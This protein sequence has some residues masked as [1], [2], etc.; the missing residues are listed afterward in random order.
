MIHPTAI[1]HPKAEVDPTV[2]VGPFAVIDENVVVGRHC[3]LGPHVYITGLTTIGAN[4]Q[5][6]A[7][8]VIGN[9]PQDLKY[10][11]DPT[12]LRIGDHNSFREHVTVNRSTNPGN[13]TVI[14]SNNLLMA[15]CHVAHDVVVGNQV[16]IAN[17]ALL[18]GHVTVGDRALISGTCL[19][20]QFVRIGTMAIMQ[21]G[22]GISQDLPP[23][24]IGRGTNFLSGLNVVG[25]RRAG[26]TREQ[27][28]ELRK[29]YHIL[30]RGPGR[31]CERIEKARAA[32]PDE[33][34]RQMIEF[35]A[36]TKRGLCSDSGSR[37]SAA[38]PKED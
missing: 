38:N 29:T 36:S 12:S 17:G 4:N 7:G 25:L 23:F 20:H 18:A 24:T 16:I 27:R 5:F 31:L 19:V 13:S 8:A 32:C 3:V 37:W 34:S 6:H 28:L 21:G 33:L 9:A 22:S 15:G 2:E 26:F 1:I 35:A 11:G 30:F 14:G 10:K